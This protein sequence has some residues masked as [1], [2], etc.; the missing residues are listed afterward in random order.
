MIDCFIDDWEFAHILVSPGN[1][2][3]LFCPSPSMIG[4]DRNPV[5][6]RLIAHGPVTLP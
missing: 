5:R 6:R 2:A 3:A 4:E 1:P